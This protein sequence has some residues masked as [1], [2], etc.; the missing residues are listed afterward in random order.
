MIQSRAGRKGI[1]GLS[2]LHQETRRWLRSA[3]RE[4]ADGRPMARL[5]NPES[6]ARYAGYMKRFI[7]YCL[8]VLVEPQ[9]D[10][11]TEVEIEEEIEESE[12][13]D[14][15]KRDYMKDARELFHWQ[16]DQ[17]AKAE[18]FWFSLELDE[19]P[20]QL[21]KFFAFMKLIIFRTLDHDLFESPLIH[22]LAIL[23]IN[24]ETNRLRNADNYSFMLAGV[25][26]C[27][28]V[29]A[30]E[31][32]LPIG[33]R[34]DQ[35]EFHRKRFLYKRKRY[36]ADGSY[37]AMSTMISLLAYGKHI[38]LNTSNAGSTH[39]STDKKILYYHGKPIII[40]RFQKMISDTIDEAE[41]MLWEELMWTR[42]SDR[43]VV[44][45]DE[46][47][48]D[49]TFTKRGISFIN[50]SSNGFADGVKWMLARM[51]RHEKGKA[52]R[53]KGSWHIRQVRRYIKKIDSFLELLLYVVHTTGGQPARG[54]EIT[55]VRY[56]NGFL[57]DRNI[58]VID[59]RVAFITRYHKTQSQFDAPKVIP[60]FMPWRVGQL[61]SVYL[62]YV[63]QFKEHLMVQVQGS[64]WS[65]YLWADINGPWETERL[66][67][68][69]TRET[70]IKLNNRLTTL[71]YRHVA[72]T[73][74]RMF[75][76]DRFGQGYREEIGKIEEPE[77]N[78]KME[79]ELEL[80]AGRSEKI[81]SQRY[82][83]STDIVKHLS[84]RSIEI[85]RSLSEAWHKF[86]DLE[87]KEKEKVGKV[88]NNAESS[89]NS[90]GKHARGDSDALL[91]GHSS[92]E[93][94]I[95]LNIRNNVG[96]HSEVVERAEE[97]GQR[98]HEIRK[99]GFEL[100]QPEE[101][102]QAMQK[103]LGCQ[104]VGFRSKEQ[105]IAMKAILN[106][107]TPLIII[108]P[109]G[110]G[111]SLL[112]MVPGCLKEGG[113]TIVV[114]P[115]RA[116]VNDLVNRL[117]KMGIDSIEW[118]SGENNAAAIVVVSADVAGSWGFLTYASLLKRQG[119]LK[120]VFIDE[121]HL[122]FTSSDYRP[123]LASLKNL[124]AVGCQMILMTATLPP[125]LEYELEESMLVRLGRYI[126]ASTVREN[127]RYV[128][129]Q[130]KGMEL[131]E[132]AVSIC[133]RQLRRMEGQKGVIYCRS[134]KQC[135]QVAEEL[136]CG[137]YHAG[138]LD[139]EI[140]LEQWL[141]KG[142]FITAT[143]ALG[144]G[145]DYK[146]ITFVLHVGMPYGMIDFAQES[147]RAGR[148]GEAVDSMVLVGEEEMEAKNEEVQR[149]DEKAMRQFVQARGC[150]RGAMSEYLDGQRIECGEINGA[151][152]DKCGEGQTEWQEW[153]A[154]K[155]KEW[156]RVR[157]SLDELKNG[158][159]AC[160]IMDEDD[161]NYMHSGREC[162]KYEEL[163]E[164]KCDEFRRRI[165]YKK[166]SHSCT[167]CGMSQKLCVTG[168]KDGMKCQWPNIMIT[169]IR[170]GMANW[171]GFSIIQKAGF[172]GEYRDWDEYS[173]WLGLRH[174]SRV[175]G[176]WMSN[177]NLVMMKIILYILG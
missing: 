50:R 146:G 152:C 18:Q 106:E 170:A 55:S 167:K 122:I 151:M 175:W 49:V 7:Y 97:Q 149:I 147:G 81:G 5:Q 107:E 138:Y 78:I 15:N 113:V 160:W 24:E 69:I 121:C 133:L 161:E 94:N 89:F 62:G 70:A 125:L 88:G 174:E 82:G 134:R 13:E 127:I 77:I 41:Q 32:L 145:V 64:G 143:S 114:A 156:K 46:I 110:G 155:E 63:Q 100:A 71:D 115:F 163:S 80:Q 43:F 58:F 108:L 154:N 28:R 135:E 171:E 79:S 21:D 129:R 86:L 29:L 68:I 42:A 168:V 44:P 74:G 144:T 116:L 99:N 9:P 48:D 128:V 141:E 16:G 148:G 140:D 158:C 73:M 26:Y 142:G 165:R 25:V 36:L 90:N 91:V 33:Q 164:Q 37:S 75:V 177:G 150:R 20:V 162:N 101:V 59:G 136:E 4:E 93:R 109:T 23:G 19:E 85:F 166:S 92:I 119:L 8:R 30:A 35:G 130:C 132:N 95:A 159:V 87:S 53:E 105:E 40:K 72:I 104:E 124:R 111:K 83:V 2:T 176:E 51:S 22:F 39:W 56:Q 61:V 1:I 66:T 102:K 27:I 57:Q 76:G 17:K 11:E 126:R 6:Q 47:V 172:N 38:A 118:T 60:R 169:I 98:Q 45:L 10:E 120:R 96:R 3:K 52:M 137:Y 12:S 31:I 103:A 14:E 139:K 112:F 123:K 34:K 65:D 131:I 84:V 157:A 67:R 117:K 153:N 173:R 54:S